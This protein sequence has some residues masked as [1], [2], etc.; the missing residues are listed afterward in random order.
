[1]RKN[2]RSADDAARVAGVYSE[3]PVAFCTDVLGDER[4]WARQAEMLE[5]VRDHRRTAVRSG[6]GVGKSWTVAR[7]A[8]WWLYTRPWSAVITTA[9]TERQVREVIWRE[10]ARAHGA[11]RVSLGGRLLTSRIQLDA[12]WFALGCS[13]DEAERFQG[14]HSASLLVIFDEAAGIP[15]RMWEAAEGMLSSRGS[16]MLAVGNP[17]APSGPFFSACSSP[18]WRHIRVSCEEAAREAARLGLSRLVS[19]EWIDERRRSWGGDSPVFRARVLGEFP[20]TVESGLVPAEWV[21]A[22]LARR[23]QGDA[24]ASS[25]DRPV[26]G[27][28]VARFGDYLTAIVLRR[29][30]RVAEAQ[31]F[32]GID[33]MEV[34]GQIVRAARAWGVD[35]HDVHVDETG[36][37]AGVVD[38]LREQGH[39]VSGH[40]FAA[41]AAN[42]AEFENLRAEI[43]WR[44]RTALSPSATEALAIEHRLDGLARQLLWIRYRVNSSGRIQI[45]SKDRIRAVEGS[46]PDLADALALTFAGYMEREAPGLWVI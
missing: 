15:R 34:A 22:A 17:A 35:W 10:I 46:S 28:D 5:A 43:Y 8:L 38:R 26:M 31:T 33:T 36:V 42:G 4:P 37:G 21:A 24:E 19:A 16:R 45:E 41:S 40:N 2:R 23:P 14:F 6:H 44:L 7:A 25:D 1:M 13:T 39:Y 9:P 27:G 30:A 12:D 11:S 20:T 3:D 29:G 18:E 32:A